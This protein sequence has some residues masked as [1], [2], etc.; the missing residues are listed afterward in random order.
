MENNL[1]IGIQEL[2]GKLKNRI[3]EDA[4]SIAMLEATVDVYKSKIIEM[5]KRLAILEEMQSQE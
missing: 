3:A 1:E 2:L 4:Q 5:Q